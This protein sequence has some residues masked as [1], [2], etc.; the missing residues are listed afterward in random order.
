MIKSQPQGISHL[1]KIVCVGCFLR[2]FEFSWK[3]N[4]PCQRG[5][6]NTC[7]TGK[8]DIWIQTKVCLLLLFFSPFL[9]LHWCAK[10]NSPNLASHKPSGVVHIYSLSYGDS[11]AHPCQKRNKYAMWKCALVRGNGPTEGRRGKFQWLIYWMVRCVRQGKTEV[12]LTGCNH[13]QADQLP[14]TELVHV[15]VGY[16]RCRVQ[17]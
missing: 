3:V 15:G 9:I 8:D 13:L 7:G 2:E 4:I 12:C 14:P 5:N 6:K 10:K 17:L 16:N 11:L 1:K